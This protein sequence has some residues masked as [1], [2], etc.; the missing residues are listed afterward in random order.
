MGRGC[1]FQREVIIQRLLRIS[2][3]GSVMLFFEFCKY[4]IYDIYI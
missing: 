2:F 3:F 1:V 4:G